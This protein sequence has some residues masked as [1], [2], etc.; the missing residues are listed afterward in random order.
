MY[1]GIIPIVQRKLNLQTPATALIMAHAG[2]PRAIQIIR[3]M[4][5]GEEDRKMPALEKTSTTPV[6]TSNANA[7]ILA[8]GGDYDPAARA[9]LQGSDVVAIDDEANADAEDDDD[10]TRVSQLRGRVSGNDQLEPQ[11]PSKR[12]RR[13]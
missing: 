9:Q 1:S 7:S 13:D 10:G 5:Q 11:G 3:S 12:A 2:D 6:E 4:K 8:S